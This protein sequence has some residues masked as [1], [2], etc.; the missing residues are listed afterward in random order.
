MLKV[1]VKKEKWLL[2][3]RKKR[4]LKVWKWSTSKS[5]NWNEKCSYGWIETGFYFVIEYRRKLLKDRLSNKE[6]QTKLV[7]KMLGDV[8]N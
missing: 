6:A 2:I 4:K 8:K 5:S 3:Q 1:H 7:E